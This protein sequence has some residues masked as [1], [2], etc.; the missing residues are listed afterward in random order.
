MKGSPSPLSLDYKANPPKISVVFFDLVVSSHSVHATGCSPTTNMAHGMG[1]LHRPL[2]MT[3]GCGVNRLVTSFTSNRV[4]GLFLSFPSP[5]HPTLPC[6]TWGLSLVSLSLQG[7]YL[8]D[9]DLQVL[10][11]AT[12]K[13]SFLSS[14]ALTQ[15]HISAQTCL[16]CI[17][18]AFVFTAS[19]GVYVLECSA[20]CSALSD[21]RVGYQE[22][23]FLP[24]HWSCKWEELPGTA[25]NRHQTLC[26]NPPWLL[27][28]AGLG[29]EW[30]LT[31]I[32]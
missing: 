12:L 23:F 4:Q 22:C 8:C 15:E 29:F 2:Q 31:C 30:S 9:K 32:A 25:Q 18:V 20:G 21:P 11:P 3:L 7:L 17:Y 24:S 16:F 19:W 1:K 28:G 27:V 13:H 26:W 10:S 5:F 14:H 6:C